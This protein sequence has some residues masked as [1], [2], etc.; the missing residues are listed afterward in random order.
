MC[1]GSHFS[2]IHL[3][4]KRTHL[5]L[6]MRFGDNER[7]FGRR[8]YDVVSPLIK[9]GLSNPSSRHPSNSNHITPPKRKDSADEGLRVAWE[10]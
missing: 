8:P 4:G 1:Y 5:E 7:H 10:Q 3:A 2:D 9:R 6:L